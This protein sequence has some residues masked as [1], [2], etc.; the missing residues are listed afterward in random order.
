MLE[1]R[2]M[3]WVVLNGVL[4]L[5]TALAVLGVQLSAR[6]W[7]AADASVRRYAMA[8]STNNAEAALAEIA[9]DQRPQW[10]TFV[11]EQLGD[12]Y[13]VRSVAVRTPSVIGRITQGLAMQPIEV[14]TVMDVNKDVQGG[15]YQPTTRV[16]V[17][18][19]DG[20]AYLAAPLLALP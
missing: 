5:T 13:D 11:A 1:L 9:P 15:F 7:G 18:L 10:A 3:R 19:V 8:V 12:H 14:T 4:A 16:P 6:D 20:R 2:P 17:E